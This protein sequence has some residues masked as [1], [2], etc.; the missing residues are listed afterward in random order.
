MKTVIGVGVDEAFGFAEGG[1]GIVETG[2]PVYAH[3]RIE[4]GEMEARGAELIYLGLGLG[5]H[6][7][8]RCAPFVEFL[9]GAEEVAFG[10]VEGW[11]CVATR[12]G[13]PAGMCPFCIEGEMATEGDATEVFKDIVSMAEVIATGH[14]ADVAGDAVETG[15]ANGVIG[16]AGGGSVVTTSNEFDHEEKW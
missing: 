15:F 12:N 6:L 16:T 11:D 5:E 10:V 1:K 13:G 3:V 9:S 14:D 7:V 4:V 2:K 8:E